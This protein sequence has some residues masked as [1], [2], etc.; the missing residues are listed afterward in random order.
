MAHLKRPIL[1]FFVSLACLSL[2]ACSSSESDLGTSAGAV[3]HNCAPRA[4][5]SGTCAYVDKLYVGPAE[6]APSWSCSDAPAR[7]EVRPGAKITATIAGFGFP[8]GELYRQDIRFALSGDP[9]AQSEGRLMGSTGIDATQTYE[10][11]TSPGSATITAT[12]HDAAGAAVCARS[13]EIVTVAP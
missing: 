6:A 7:V 13:I 8:P 10:T 12:R 9:S 1:S 3:W 5:D 2:A 4:A 11:R